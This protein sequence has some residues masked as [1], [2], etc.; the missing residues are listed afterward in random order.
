MTIPLGALIRDKSLPDLGYGVV[1]EQL[2]EAS[3]V[4]FETGPP[5]IVRFDHQDEI[6]RAALHPGQRV[7]VVSKGEGLIL[8]RT[9]E[10]A[11]RHDAG[12][13]AVIFMQ[14][15]SLAMRQTF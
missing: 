5:R 14:S 1:I 7:E 4:A 11:P 12:S 10:R 3:R 8:R 9:R 6:S 2:D 13:D 15:E